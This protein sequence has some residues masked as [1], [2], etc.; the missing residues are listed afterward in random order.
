MP[1]V[2]FATAAAPDPSP[3]HEHSPPHCHCYHIG[4]FP[5]LPHAEAK[6]ACLAVLEELQKNE[7]ELI[8]LSKSKETQ[9]EKV[10]ALMPKVQAILA[11]PITEFGFPVGPMGLMAGMA[12][13]NKAAQPVDAQ[14]LGLSEIK[15]GTPPSARPPTLSHFYPHALRTH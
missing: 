4:F 5:C 1:Q 10:A 2:P 15:E 9:Q 12:A 11:K 8:D 3:L 13:M 14:G 7:K 6:A